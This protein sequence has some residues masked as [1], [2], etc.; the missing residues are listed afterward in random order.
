MVAR[1]ELLGHGSMFQVPSLE[2]LM[3]ST[4]GGST[5]GMGD[6]VLFDPTEIYESPSID[7][8][9]SLH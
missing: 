2:M 5:V 8:I 4:A 1:S 3:G 7:V 6:H 9:G